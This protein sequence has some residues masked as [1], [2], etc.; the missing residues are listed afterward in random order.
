M[1]LTAAHYCGCLYSTKLHGH[2]VGG[3][4]TKLHGYVHIHRTRP[5]L[6]QMWSHCTPAEA[7]RWLV[8]CCHLATCS[9]LRDT[10]LLQNATHRLWVQ[11]WWLGGGISVHFT[12]VI[13]CLHDK[14]S[15]PSGLRKNFTVW[16]TVKMFPSSVPSHCQAPGSLSLGP[17]AYS[18]LPS[19][20]ARLTLVC[21]GNHT[22]H[23]HPN[24]VSH[25][26]RNL[27]K[28][29]KCRIACG[30]LACCCMWCAYKLRGLCVGG[31][32]GCLTRCCLGSN[33]GVIDMK[34][35]DPQICLKYC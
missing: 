12:D 9:D 3:V 4:R 20:P 22:Q 31:F 17:R 6:R 34:G 11:S 28:F 1:L 8:R 2:R 33:Q 15:D 7:R 35:N 30:W 16:H 25:C 23:L 32:P 26:E 18:L 10:V 27:G 21:H 24:T 19:F 29:I 5:A 14:V 13:V